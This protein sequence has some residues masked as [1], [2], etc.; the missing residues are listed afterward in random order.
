MTTVRTIDIAV[1]LMDNATAK[2][3]NIRNLM[4]QIQRSVNVNVDANSG[5]NKLGQDANSA[6]SS[7][8]NSGRVMSDSLGKVGTSAKHTEEAFRKTNNATRQFSNNMMLIATVFDTAG[9][10]QIGNKF[11]SASLGALS[12]S[13]AGYSLGNAFNYVKNTKISDAAEKASSSFFKLGANQSV[14]TAGGRALASIYYSAASAMNVFSTGSLAAVGSLTLLSAAAAAVIVLAGGIFAAMAMPWQSL[15]AQV[16]KTT[17]LSGS[18]LNEVSAA[19]LQMGT[20]AGIAT[21]DLAQI[22]IIAGQVGMSSKTDILDFTKAVSTAAIAWNMTGEAAGIAISKISNIYNIQP[23]HINDLSS[24]ITTLANDTAATEREVLDFM[25]TL[26]NSM[27]M[28]G[29]TAAEAAA[30]GATLTSLGID[31]SRAGTEVNSAIVFMMRA[32]N[33][34]KVARLTGKSEDQIAG[35]DVS[36]TLIEVGAALE[37]LAPKERSETLVDIAGLIGAKAVRP[38]T[39]ANIRNDLIKNTLNAQASAYLGQATEEAASRR[40][41]TG[42]AELQNTK[43]ILRELIYSVGMALLPIF[44]ELLRIFNAVFKVVSAVVG[45]FAR[46]FEKLDIFSRLFHIIG[47]TLD[48]VAQIIIRVIKVI[49]L[50]FGWLG[51]ALDLE[52]GDKALADLDAIFK[53]IIDK[54]DWLLSLIGAEPVDKEQAF[55]KAARE[56]PVLAKTWTDK[57]GTP[58][59]D[60]QEAEAKKVTFTTEGL[61]ALKYERENH[62]EDAA[63]KMAEADWFIQQFKVKDTGISTGGGIGKGYPDY[64]RPAGVTAAGSPFIAG[65]TY[66]KNA[67]GE[68]AILRV[69]EAGYFET[70]AKFA[71]DTS[72]NIKKNN[73]Q[74]DL[75]SRVISTILDIIKK[76]AE[77][78]DGIIKWFGD[79]F[80]KILNAILSLPAQI[81]KGA[82]EMLIALLEKLP[83]SAKWLLGFGDLESGGVTDNFNTWKDNF[84]ES[85]DNFCRGVL[86]FTDATDAANGTDTTQQVATAYGGVRFTYNGRLVG[87][88]PHA[89]GGAEIGSEGPVI[90]QKKEEVMNPAD[91][92]AGPG[93]ISKAIHA[94][95]TATTT[96]NNSS[97]SNNVVVNINNPIVRDNKDIREIT[98]QMKS[99][100]KKI[101]EEHNIRSE[102]QFLN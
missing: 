2:L 45:G 91:V 47:S 80:D 43:N 70:L 72:K 10:Y 41:A 78:I 75:L 3:T 18:A 74:N 50:L 64:V 79:I 90:L 52:G 63:N 86:N 26:G 60:A 38:L 32:E 1:N 57:Y 17:E 68:L 82:S 9:I 34:G 11:Y 28:F 39:D 100:L 69:N 87:G 22:A 12:L 99:E 33:I 29:A 85:V 14:A 73:D 36:Q 44:T 62:G 58:M 67:L 88:L 16:A 40:K 89:H 61:N 20:S 49:E 15:M 77:T 48:F 93:I 59:T 94:L 92:H 25:Q 31:A 66:Q 65:A 96:S 98:K 53:F 46:I 84:R 81:V 56:N 23:D 6:A 76:I 55:A 30:L 7:I 42:T 21:N 5:F 19:L 24:A 97:Q 35:Q 27:Q 83:D 102:R 95:N 8:R 4:N 37:K 54:I 51:K 71:E 13:R 101:I